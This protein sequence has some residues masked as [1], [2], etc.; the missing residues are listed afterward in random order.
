MQSLR[1]YWV[2][3]AS[4]MDATLD[5]DP[6][7]VP[8]AGSK[9]GRNERRKLLATLLN[10]LCAASLIAAIVQPAVTLVRQERHFTTLDFVTMLVFGLI[11]LT[12]HTAGRAIAASLED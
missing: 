11:G 3:Y 12:L 7:P 10:N 1:L 2:C 6:A 4:G 5:E 8:P 9:A